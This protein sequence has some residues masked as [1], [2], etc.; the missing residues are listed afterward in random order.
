MKIRAWYSI[1]F[2]GQGENAVHLQVAKVLENDGLD[3]L[4]RYCSARCWEMTY[5]ERQGLLK[6]ES[7][8]M[9]GFY[10][11]ASISIN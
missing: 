5:D 9:F 7:S 6:I 11:K 10:G 4:K 8:V 1:K 3:G 2:S